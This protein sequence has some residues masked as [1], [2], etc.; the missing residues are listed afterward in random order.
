MLTELES[1][2][3]DS[4]VVVV[5]LKTDRGTRP[6]SCYCGQQLG[7]FLER[8]RRTYRFIVLGVIGRKPFRHRPYG[9]QAHA[10]HRVYF[11]H[12]S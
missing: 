6:A 4:P 11:V 8:S 3:A 5:Y 1:A 10:S 2:L 9:K 7:N 12:V